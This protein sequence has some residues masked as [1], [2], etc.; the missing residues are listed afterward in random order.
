MS[1]ICRKKNLHPANYHY[2][3][4]FRHLVKWCNVS[5]SNKMFSWCWVLHGLHAPT[6]AISY[7]FGAKFFFF[8][9]RIGLATL[10]IC[11]MS[12]EYIYI[13]TCIQHQVSFLPNHHEWLW[14]RSLVLRVTWCCL[15]AS[16]SSLWVV[17]QLP[18]PLSTALRG[19]WHCLSTGS[20][21]HQTWKFVWLGGS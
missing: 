5:D 8:F 16:L 7:Q 13:Y 2:C 9:F 4:S 10:P 15:V 19:P 6:R 20:K 1:P 21:C 17:F 11:P 3:F 14:E 12:L 18:C